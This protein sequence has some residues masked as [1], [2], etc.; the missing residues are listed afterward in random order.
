MI[1]RNMSSLMLRLSD[2]SHT[3]SPPSGSK[4]ASN[5]RLVPLLSTPTSVCGQSPPD[6]G[7][8]L[9]SVVQNAPKNNEQHVSSHSD[10]LSVLK[11]QYCINRVIILL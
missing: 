1:I 10:L 4:T 2:S 9:A 3:S 8:S 5:C 6:T 11:G 7:P